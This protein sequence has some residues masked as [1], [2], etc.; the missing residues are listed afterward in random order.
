MKIVH[1]FWPC[2]GSGGKGAEDGERTSVVILLT[3][4]ISYLWWLQSKCNCCSFLSMLAEV[5]DLITVCLV[6]SGLEISECMLSLQCLV[7]SERF[8]KCEESCEIFFSIPT[9]QLPLWKELHI[10]V[11]YSKEWARQSARPILLMIR[12]CTS[13]VWSYHLIIY[14]N[15]GFHSAIRCPKL[16]KIQKALWD[17][18]YRLIKILV[19]GSRSSWTFL[20]SHL[21]D[22][23]PAIGTVKVTS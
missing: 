20:E 5:S 2:K 7:H 21:R 22:F 3:K 13:F 4:V 23:V 17:E 19:L 15:W 6:V 11:T 12:L 10:Y 1:N 9:S 8:T 18:L 14:Y 16:L